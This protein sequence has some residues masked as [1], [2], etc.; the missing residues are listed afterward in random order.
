THLTETGAVVGTGEYISPEQAAGKQATRRSDLYS[1]GVVL[2]TLLTGRTPF[3]GK[4]PAELLHKHIYGQFD[5][6][7]RFVPDL[8]YEID[9]L[10]CQLLEKDP[11]RR[12]SDGGV[13]HRQLDN[14]R[15]KL[16]RK[17]QD[18]AIAPT[19]AA[20]ERTVPLPG[21][22]GREGPATMMSRLV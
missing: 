21:R 4:N 15:C 14:I 19:V 9:D 20:S 22:S 7:S 12:P 11:D 17:G 10:V 6:P 8:P 18:A 2:Y 5:K 1:L 16:E 13:L 3:Q